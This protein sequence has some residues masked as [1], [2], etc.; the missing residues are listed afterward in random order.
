MNNIKGKKILLLGGSS[1]LIPVIN[2][3]HDLGIETITCDYL[4]NNAAHK[5][6]DQYVNLSVVDQEAILKKSEELNID[7]IISFACD[8]GVVTASYVAE[9]LGLPFQGP[10]E[11]VKILQDK[12]LFRKFL[13]ENG[14]NSPHAKS[15]KCVSDAIKDKDYFRWPVIVKPVDSAGS[16][17][18]TRVDDPNELDDAAN[19]A[20]ANSLSH[21]F[22]VEDF[23]RFSGYHSSADDFTVNGELKFCTYSDQLFDKNAKNPYAPSLIVWP[24]TMSQTNQNYLTSETQRLMKL[25]K[26]KTGIY[27]IESCI[28]E[29][30]NPYLMEVS[31]RGGGCQI[32][33]VQKLATGIDLIEAEI[34]KAVNVPINIQQSKINGIWC[35]LVIHSNDILGRFNNVVIDQNIKDKYIKMIDISVKQGEMIYPFTGGNKAIGNLIMNFNNRDEMRDI[36]SNKSKWLKIIVD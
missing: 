12:G 13:L 29:N 2:K 27:N 21:R 33:V 26:M 31:P 4:P 17:G 6:S 14:F 28:D 20:L 30:D 7:G 36:I 9:K 16:K 32:A 11:S 3:C 1:V 8:A 23:L 10:Y 24:T 19:A 15:Y 34:L 18:V 25:L 35:V 22:I 5:Y